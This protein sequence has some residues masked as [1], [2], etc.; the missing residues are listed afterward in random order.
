MKSI[1]LAS[2]LFLGCTLAAQFD[3][4]SAQRLAQIS[5]PVLDNGIAIG[6]ITVGVSTEN[7]K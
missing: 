6:A 2:A 5:V 7:L 4:S 3:D 1:L